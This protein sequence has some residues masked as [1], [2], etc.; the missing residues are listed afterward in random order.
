MSTRVTSIQYESNIGY[1]LGRGSW[2]MNV[3]DSGLS[4]DGRH[5]KGRLPLYAFDLRRSSSYPLLVKRI[6]LMG[7]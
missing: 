3:K 2:R 4:K 1:V 5:I 7:L 6:K